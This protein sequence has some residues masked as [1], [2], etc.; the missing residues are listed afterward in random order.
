MEY[1]VQVG[2]SA[3]IKA[4]IPSHAL[5][6]RESLTEYIFENYLKEVLYETEYISEWDVEI[7]PIDSD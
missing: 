4:K 2:I 5:K 7:S 3:N 1:D 6:S